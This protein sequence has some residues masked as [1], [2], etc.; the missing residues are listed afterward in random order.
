MQDRIPFAV[1]QVPFAVEFVPFAVAESLPTLAMVIL[2]AQQVH[3]C[4]RQ[5]NSKNKTPLLTCW[6]K[7]AAVAGAPECSLRH[8]TLAQR[9]HHTCSHITTGIPF[10]DK[11]M[12]SPA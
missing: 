5:V 3:E 1:A 2:E 9:Y 12:P 4:L 7:C 6:R 10:A 8:H 11:M